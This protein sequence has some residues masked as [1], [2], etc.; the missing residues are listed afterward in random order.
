MLQRCLLV[1]A[2]KSIV[3]IMTAGILPSSGVR[4][5]L[6]VCMVVDQSSKRPY[7]GVMTNK[8]AEMNG[9]RFYFTVEHG[10]EYDCVLFADSLEAATELFREDFGYNVVIDGVVPA[11]EGLV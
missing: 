1:V 3:C 8:G 2:A 5:N 7:N 10:A 11:G 9:Y 4:N 6:T